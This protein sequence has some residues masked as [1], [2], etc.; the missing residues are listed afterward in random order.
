VLE[1]HPLSTNRILDRIAAWREDLINLNRNNRLLYFRKT[2]SSTLELRHPSASDLL[3]WIANGKPATFWE[4]PK[5][6]VEIS[7][8]DAGVDDTSPV[9][10]IDAEEETDGREL[11]AGP[12]KRLGSTDEIV[13]D[14]KTRELLFKSLRWLERRA[15]QEFMD[16]GLWILYLGIGILDW[17]DPPRETGEPEKV[18]SPIILIPVQLH[19][20][21][22][23]S[24]YQI[25]R[26]DEDAA[27]NPA[28]AFKLQH[29]FGI[30]LPVFEDED[31]ED[32]EAFLDSVRDAIR[33]K[34]EWGIQNRIVL[35]VF[36]FHKEA[37]CRDLQNN[38]AIVIEHPIIQNL[39]LGH[40]S[41][42]SITFDPTPEET[43]DDVH[44]PESMVSILDCD[45][46]QRQC[47]SA[48]AAGHSFV[49]DGPPGTGKSQTIANMIADSLARAKTVLFV[50]EKAAALE[51]VQTRLDTAGLRIEQDSSDATKLLTVSDRRWVLGRPIVQNQSWG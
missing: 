49:M 18:S 37:M 38:E 31:E 43:L 41:P 2:K 4:P 39:A 13:C 5:E 9:T 34:A 3:M 44:P 50:S 32:V 16:K 33:E 19:R 8:T 29:D 27:I 20:E 42:N 7:D 23:Q 14:I 47:L 17:I 11:F 26:A 22:A 24:P 6:N 48:A 15:A 10:L 25:S 40:R 35:S 30:T 51:V 12:D 45:S 21:S 36:S 46:S 28:L 1:E